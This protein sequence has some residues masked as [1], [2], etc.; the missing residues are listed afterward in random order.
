MKKRRNEKKKKSS[1]RV[2]SF[3]LTMGEIQQGHLFMLTISCTHGS[4]HLDYMMDKVKFEYQK[5]KE[6]KKGFRCIS[7]QQILAIVT[8]KASVINCHYN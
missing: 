2:F 3:L 8:V 7:L 6:K 4:M 5:G 1:L